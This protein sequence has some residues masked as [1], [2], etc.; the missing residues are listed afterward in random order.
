MILSSQTQAALRPSLSLK[1]WPQAPRNAEKYT[2]WYPVEAWADMGICG[3]LRSVVVTTFSEVSHVVSTRTLYS[4]SPVLP[5]TALH[6][7]P[8]CL[9]LHAAAGVGGCSLL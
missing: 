8:I 2:S 5:N 3:S 1:A 4:S 7:L 6:T 9:L